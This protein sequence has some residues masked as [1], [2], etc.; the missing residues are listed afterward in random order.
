MTKISPSPSP[1]PPFQKW[2]FFILR[3]SLLGERVGV[4]GDLRVWLLFGYWDLVIGVLV[5]Q[6]T[7]FFRLG[8]K[9]KRGLD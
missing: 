7:S 9:P 2:G 1:S 8:R 4:R 6:N 3:H 5:G